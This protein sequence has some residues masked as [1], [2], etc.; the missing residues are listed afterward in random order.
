MTLFWFGFGIGFVAGAGGLYGF[1][2]LV[3]STWSQ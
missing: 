2:K 1:Y 3:L